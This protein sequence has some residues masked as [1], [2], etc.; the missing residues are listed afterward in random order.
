MIAKN[1][2]QEVRSMV[3]QERQWK[4]GRNVGSECDK[5]L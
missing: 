3:K 2:I 4:D 5:V 1:G